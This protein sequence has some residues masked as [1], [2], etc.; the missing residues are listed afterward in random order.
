MMMARHCPGDGLVLNCIMSFCSGLWFA[1]IKE[2]TLHATQEHSLHRCAAGYDFT[3]GNAGSFSSVSPF[4]LLFEIPFSVSKDIRL[5]RKAIGKKLKMNGML[6]NNASLS[7]IRLGS[8]NTSYGTFT[9][10]NGWMDGKTIDDSSSLNVWNLHKVGCQILKEPDLT[11]V[12]ANS[13]LLQVTYWDRASW[14]Y[15]R[16]IDVVWPPPPPDYM[17][18]NVAES[19]SSSSAD[20]SSNP[21]NAWGVNDLE[22]FTNYIGSCCG[23]SISDIANMK[24]LKYPSYHDFDLKKIAQEDA[25]RLASSTFKA[26]TFSRY[27]SLVDCERLIFYISTVPLKKLTK[28]E[29]MI[30]NIELPTCTTATSSSSVPG[31]NSRSSYSTTTSTS[32]Y[33]KKV[34]KGLSIKTKKQR[35]QEAKEQKESDT[36]CG[37]VVLPFI[38]D[39]VD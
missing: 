28:G 22:R 34:E 4:T 26:Q 33:K 13:I 1:P 16:P 24:I 25:V 36:R 19:S 29:E 23:L 18:D 2:E 9:N 27:Y 30:T 3:I 21:T 39:D 5:L 12:N 10:T 11:N 8:Y 17:T 38:V 7:R 32:T 6:P 14:T 15:G 31:F 37:S 35:D 20:S